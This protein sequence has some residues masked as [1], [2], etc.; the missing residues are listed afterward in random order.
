MNWIRKALKGL[1]LTSAMFVF[2]ACYG[3]GPDYM[4]QETTFHV[5]ADDT[6]NPLEGMEVFVGS[7]EDVD[8][9]DVVT[10]DADGYVS[11][12]VCS[13]YGSVVGFSIFDKD[14][15][16]N[17]VDTLININEADTVEIRMTKKI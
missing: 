1:S 8:T 5:V 13:D 14:S 10:T 11:I 3:T 6:G 2:Q 9:N 15:V 4:C 7:R 17:P 12:G 16:Y